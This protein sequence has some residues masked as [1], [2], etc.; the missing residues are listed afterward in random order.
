[1]KIQ[2]CNLNAYESKLQSI[3]LSRVGVERL[4][5]V[6]A[7]PDGRIVED[8]QPIFGAFCEFVVFNECVKRPFYKILSAILNNKID[9]L[10]SVLLAKNTAAESSLTYKEAFDY[11]LLIGK[12]KVRKILDAYKC[13]S[14]TYNAIL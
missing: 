14:Y 13:S 10:F 5:Q 2:D 12:N 8:V 6:A 7:W 9:A 1:M 11:F 3:P 4:T